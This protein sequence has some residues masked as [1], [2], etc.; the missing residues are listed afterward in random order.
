MRRRVLAL[1]RY[2][3]KASSSRLRL[4]LFIDELERS[5]FDIDISNFFDDAYLAAIYQRRRPGI[6]NVT[7]AFLRRLRAIF[8]LSRYDL[9]WVEKEMLPFCPAWIERRLMPRAAR[10]IYDFDD[11][12]DQRYKDLKNPVARYVL[13]GKIE[14]LVA[15]IDA[16]T[17]PNNQMAARYRRFSPKRFQVVSGSI[18]LS[19]YPS[20]DET[21]PDRREGPLQVGWIG[22]PLNADKHLRPVTELLNNLSRAGE[23][24]VCLIGAGM[25]APELIATRVDWREDTEI[26][27]IGKFDVGIMP[28]E[29]GVFEQGK[30]GFKL[31]QYMACA[32]AV[33]ASPTEFNVGLIHQSGAGL[34]AGSPEDWIAAL[35]RMRWDPDTLR[36][37][38]RAGQAFVH[39]HYDHRIR[40][41]E[42]AAL[43][44]DVIAGKSP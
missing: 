10:F 12:W 39:R 33:I 17:L 8:S 2:T 11:D 22:T 25:S 5:G 13:G 41:R 40:A 42:I 44:D 34:I 16:V 1:T 14:R 26:D 4:C 35:T 15:D 27:E 18:D 9:V 20:P 29:I 24:Q 19:A 37:F 3:R 21:R 28:L 23:I 43:F 6:V 32:K 31:I 7:L 38:G 36:A 30:S